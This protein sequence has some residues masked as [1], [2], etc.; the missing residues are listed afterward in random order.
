LVQTTDVMPLDRFDRRTLLTAGLLAG[1]MTR[2]AISQEKDTGIKKVSSALAL[3]RIVNA[4]VSYATLRPVPIKYAKM[5]LASTLSGAAAGAKIESTRIIREI[6]KEQGGKAEAT[7]WFDGARLPASSAARVNAMLSDAYASDDSDLRNVAHI[8][9]CLTAVGLAIGER[10]GASGEETLSAM[11]AGYEVAGRMT[12]AIAASAP[13][14]GRGAGAISGSLG[15]GF[16]ASSIVAF[17]G[18]VTAAKLLRLTDEQMAQAI[19]IT[20]TTVGGLAIG[21]NSWAREYHAG[22]AALT[23][24]NAALAAGRGYT[25]NPDM[26]EAPGG[27]LAVFSGGTPD[28]GSLVRELKTGSDDGYQIARYLAVKLVPGAHA[29]HPATEAAVNAARESNAGPEDVA[30]ILVAGP[31]SG[32]VAGTPPKDVIQAIHSLSYYIASAVA[33]KDFS[34]VHAEPAMIERPVVRRLIGLVAQDPAPDP[35]RYEWPWGATVTIVTRSGARFASTVDAPR[36]SAPRGIEWSDI[37]TKYRT[38]MAQSTLPEDR[39]AE[40]LQTI[41]NFEQVKSVS[42]L[43]SLLHN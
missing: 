26:L 6:A 7:I 32:L 35:V 23:S 39:I 8:G 29:L 36:G 15:R 38:L 42:R 14:A 25:V 27:F 3:A 17:G 31:Q 30:Q 1:G 2:M 33:D 34:W 4:P 16:H 11:V 40:I 21:T 28:A 41:R 9:T 13:S 5:I 20:A 43:T 18:A 12:D 24:I 19:G 37:E 22:N 10:T